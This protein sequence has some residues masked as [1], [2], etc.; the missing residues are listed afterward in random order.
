MIH[1]F[2]V[3]HDDD[4]WG[5]F[6]SMHEPMALLSQTSRDRGHTEEQ[7]ENF[8]FHQSAVEQVDAESPQ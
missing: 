3:I 2:A 8:F 4:R 7:A 5:P 1:Y 6:E